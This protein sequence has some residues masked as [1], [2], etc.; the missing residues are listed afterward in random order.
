MNIDNIN[1]ISRKR[2]AAKASGTGG[3]WFFGFIGTLVYFLHEHS[4]TFWLVVLA[5]IK[6]VVWPALLVYHVLLFMEV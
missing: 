4:G 5:I 2:H 6:A 1:H 3:L